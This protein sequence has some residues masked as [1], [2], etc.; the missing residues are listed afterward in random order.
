MFA[1]DFLA[2]RRA[3]CVRQRVVTTPPCRDA[4]DKHV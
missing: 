2:G 4:G 1:A 3:V